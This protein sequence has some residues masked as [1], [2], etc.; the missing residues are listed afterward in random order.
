MVDLGGHTGNVI[1]Q[2]QFHKVIIIIITIIIIIII[3]PKAKEEL[4]TLNYKDL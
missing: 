2:L 1:K 4:S 3:N